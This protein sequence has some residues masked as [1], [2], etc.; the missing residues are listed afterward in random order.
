MEDASDTSEESSDQDTSTEEKETITTSPDAI[1][2]A[3]S[4]ENDSSIS[5]QDEREETNA[6]TT[7][8]GD[9]LNPAELADNG[10]LIGHGKVL[11]S[12]SGED[13]TTM[14]SQEN[15][16][17]SSRAAEES[18]P[19]LVPSQSPANSMLY[20]GGD[21]EEFEGA[22][23]SASAAEPLIIESS[24]SHSQRQAATAVATKKP[25]K[26]LIEVIA[27]AEEE[28]E[29]AMEIKKNTRSIA[30]SEPS[31][32]GEKD[33]KDSKRNSRKTVRFSS[34]DIVHHIDSN[35]GDDGDSAI[36]QSGTQWAVL[37]NR[38]Q[39]QAAAA[40]QDG[41]VVEDIIDT[42]ADTSVENVSFNA[43]HEESSQDFKLS[44][45]PLVSEET[46]CRVDTALGA[47]EGK[48]SD[49]LSAEEKVWKLAASG[50]STLEEDAVTLDPQTSARLKEGL[51]KVNLLDKVS[52]KF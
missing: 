5:V 32:S 50:G 21:E 49:S 36:G 47:L 38:Q 31:K 33:G 45:V 30:N 14:P 20:I 39:Q 4:S 40:A 48:P 24:T 15:T 35:L 19:W 27:S 12:S 7:G 13:K 51:Q 11:P 1:P 22:D 41:T 10:T 16:L 23:S 37:T 18:I 26:P 17:E 46:I 25:F 34:L 52:L 2:G 44:E 29:E 28:E 3:N 43:K 6:S 8:G 9:I 42:D